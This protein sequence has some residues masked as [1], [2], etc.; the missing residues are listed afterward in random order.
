MDYKIVM[1]K[2]DKREKKAVDVQKIF[3]EYGCSI[4]VRLG[5]HDSPPESC[6]PC[7]LII[8]DVEGK[9]EEVKALVEKLNQEDFV[10]AK[11]IQI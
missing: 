1:V 5:L 9:E 10:T 4:K 3:T 6:S 2:V 7:G 8:L 11:F